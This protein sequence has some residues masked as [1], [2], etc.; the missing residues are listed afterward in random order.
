MVFCRIRQELYEEKV[1]FV[2]KY[3]RQPSTYPLF[4]PK[5]SRDVH[6]SHRNTHIIHKV[7]HKYTGY[8]FF[9]VDKT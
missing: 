5:L 4:C 1:K 3:V 9:F 2:N 8:S 7:I 6:N